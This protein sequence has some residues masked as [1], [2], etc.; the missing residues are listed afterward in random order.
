M[1]AIFLDRDGVINQNRSDYVRSWAEFQFLPGAIAAMGELSR[2]GL[3]LFVVTNQAIV[4]R[5]MISREDLDEIHRRMVRI[6]RSSGVAI[7]LD[8]VRYCPHRPDEN[9]Y[10]RK[11]NP[12]MLISLAAEHGI[13]LARSYIVG[14]ALSDIAAGQASGCRTALVQTGRGRE[15]FELP[16]IRRWRPD[17]YA[18]DLYAAVQWI[19]AEEGKAVD[20]PN[21]LRS[22]PPA[23]PG[24]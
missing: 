15:Q 14:D 19:L 4:N 3:P 8:A 11:P 13:D 20:V 9:C 22:I 7:S 5:G 23:L 2:A 10:C 17:H 1:Q 24:R 18:R 6:V 21:P 16:D 12:G